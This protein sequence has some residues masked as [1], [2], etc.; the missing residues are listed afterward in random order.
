MKERYFFR[1]QY[2]GYDDDFFMGREGGWDG[3]E[4]IVDRKGNERFW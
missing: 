2:A 3:K 4:G 1:V